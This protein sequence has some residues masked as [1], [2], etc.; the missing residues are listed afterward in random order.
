MGLLYLKGSAPKEALNEMKAV[1]GED[2]QSYDVVKHW[3]RQFKYGRTS[4]GTVPKSGHPLSTIDDAILQLIETAILEDCRVTERQLVHE[5]GL[6]KKIIRKHMHIG[7]MSAR[8]ILRLLIT[9]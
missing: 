7:N 3:H 2:A 6:W 9:L 4:V 1:Y 5:R 8:W